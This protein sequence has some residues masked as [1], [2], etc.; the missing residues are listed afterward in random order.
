MQTHLNAN[1]FKIPTAI[2]LA[3]KKT[4]VGTVFVFLYSEVCRAMHVRYYLKMKVLINFE[5]CLR[6]ARDISYIHIMVQ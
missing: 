1:A 6:A 5:H 3:Y 2:N 4:F